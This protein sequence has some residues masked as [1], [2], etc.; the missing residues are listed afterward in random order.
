MSSVDETKIVLDLPLLLLKDVNELVHIRMRCSQSTVEG[1]ATVLN[2]YWSFVDGFR[3]YHDC[4]SKA[5]RQIIYPV[6]N[7]AIFRTCSFIV[8]GFV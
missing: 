1:S 6:K 5:N 8:V 2:S 7:N 4:I 3:C